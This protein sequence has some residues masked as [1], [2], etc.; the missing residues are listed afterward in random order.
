[1]L[2]KLGEKQHV[3]TLTS[4]SVEMG[5]T[6]QKMQKKKLITYAI[7][8]GSYSYPLFSIQQHL[9]VHQ[10]VDPFQELCL[11]LFILVNNKLKY[12]KLARDICINFQTKKKQRVQ[13]FLYTIVIFASLFTKKKLKLNFFYTKKSKILSLRQTRKKTEVEFSYT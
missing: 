5:Y 13:I 11:I 10:Q 4:I 12:V 3:M 2:K 8:N 6:P 9:I 7:L 1:M